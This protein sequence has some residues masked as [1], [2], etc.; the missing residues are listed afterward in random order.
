MCLRRS[1]S[2]QIFLNLWRKERMRKRRVV[3]FDVKYEPI[4]E[5]DEKQLR[6]V[7]N[8]IISELTIDIL[9]KRSDREQSQIN[10]GINTLPAE[11]ND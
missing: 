2:T 7:L 3:T 8:S 9:R 1:G 4:S 5:D 6:I 11:A 10:T